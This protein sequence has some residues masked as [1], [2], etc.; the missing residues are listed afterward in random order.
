MMGTKKQSSEDIKG[1]P[2]V[3]SIGSTPSLPARAFEEKRDVKAGADERSICKNE[4]V[5][6]NFSLDADQMHINKIG[7][8]NR[9]GAKAD[10]TKAVILVGGYGT[11]LRPLTYTVPKPLISFCNKPILKYQ[12]EKLVNAGIKEIIL[13]LNYYSSKIIKEVRAYEQEFGIKIVYSKEDVPLG[14]AGPLALAKH[15]L[16]GSS[17]FLMNS[18]I[19]CNVDLS[20]MKEAYMGSDALGTLL[21]HG[22]DDPTRYGLIK[23]EG[24][25]IVSF[26]EKPKKTEGTGPWMINAGIYILSHEVLK[27]IELREMSIE[28]EVFPHLAD[29]GVLEGFRFE[30]YWMD[31]GQP[32]DYLRG[33][34]L[35]IGSM[36]ESA[37][38]NVTEN[39]SIDKNENVVIG[40]NVVIGTNVKLR[41][42]TIFEYTTVEDNVTVENSIIGW[43]SHLKKDSQVL[44]FSVLGQGTVIESGIQVRGCRSNPNSRFS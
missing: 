6:E 38:G 11:R 21:I 33:Q 34:Q 5:T 17:F 7:D 32:T 3:L 1:I 29:A 8:G 27:C 42:C 10:V 40:R 39:G 43:S 44:D 23:M 15:H 25:K 30:G 2:Q 9:A 31:I 41:D 28:K 18:D 16:E 14:T 13:A 4:Q 22:V 37:G 12:I 20:L 19:A 24:N 35:A 36:A 26:L